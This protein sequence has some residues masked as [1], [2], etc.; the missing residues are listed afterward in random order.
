M[1]AEHSPSR[2]VLMI[3]LPGS[4]KSAYVERVLVPQGFQVVCQDDIR[5]ACGHAFYGPLEPMVHALG[6]MQLRQHGLRGLPVVV[7]E[8]LCRVDHLRLWKRRA[9][10]LGYAVSALHIDTPVEVC[11]QRRPFFPS[12]VIDAKLADL[13]RDYEDIM[14]LFPNMEIIT[15]DDGTEEEACPASN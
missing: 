7:D 11:K 14:E 1:S 13:R 10:A 6:H 5:R 15:A 4:G 3:G 8:S 12:E 2:C 9:E